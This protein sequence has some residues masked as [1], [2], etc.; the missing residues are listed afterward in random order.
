MT[1]SSEKEIK[2][3]HLIKQP[4]QPV[5]ELPQEQAIVSTPEP[6]TEKK[7]SCCRRKKESR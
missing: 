2:K 1:E 4:K 6:T 3:V 7:K 5:Q